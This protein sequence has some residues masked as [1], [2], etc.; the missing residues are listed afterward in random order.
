MF[1]GVVDNDLPRS[2]VQE[3]K[4]L[5]NRISRTR[6]ELLEFLR[7]SRVDSTNNLSGR[8]LRPLVVVRKTSGGSRSSDGAHAHGALASRLQSLAHF[9]TS[10][11]DFVRLHF[12]ASMQGAL[13][14]SVVAICVAQECRQALTSC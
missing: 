3:V 10:F 14:F 8:E 1:K 12:V 5:K 11:L 7:S 2:Q 6:D 9:K 4:H 13:F